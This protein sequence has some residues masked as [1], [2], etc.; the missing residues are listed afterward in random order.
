MNRE[1]LLQYGRRKHAENREAANAGRL[2][3]YY[4][5]HDANK[6]KLR[7]SYVKFRVQRRVEGR[8]WFEANRD[9]DN[10]RRRHHYHA[11]KDEKRGERKL[12][13]QATRL[14]T[15]WQKLLSSARERAKR[16]GVPYDLTTEW[17]Q[18]EWT[19]R[20]ALTNIPF[21]LGEQEPGPKFFSPSIDRIVPSLGYVIGNCRFVLWAVNA[22][23]YDGTDADIYVIAEALLSNRHV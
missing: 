14:D 19:G 8:A 21:R 11:H 20:C 18:A 10:D 23:K 17:A 6:Q 22:M 4:A 13:R 9:Q 7:D 1:Q 15:P 5:S 2:A 12:K 3:R 16:K